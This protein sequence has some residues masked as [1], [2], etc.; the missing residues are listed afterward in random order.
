MTL[1]KHRPPTHPGEMLLEEFLRPLKLSQA[2]AARRLRMS[3]NRL[4]ELIKGKRGVTPDTALR[5]SELFRNSPQFW[6]GLQTDWDLWHARK[7]RQAR[8]EVRSIRPI[9]KAS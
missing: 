7:R 5:L 6:M 1:P 8:G 9:A 3:L 2:E 4:N